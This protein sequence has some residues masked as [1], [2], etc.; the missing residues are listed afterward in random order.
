MLVLALDTCDSRGSLALLRDGVVLCHAAHDVEED[1]SRWLLPAIQGLLKTAETKLA[2]IDVYAVA[3]GPGL[4]TGVRLSLAT[5][6]AW[7]EVF[8]RPIV[9]VSRL[10]ALATCGDGDAPFVGAFVDANRGQVFASLY[11][12][13]GQPGNALQPAGLQPIGEEMVIA[14]E[15]FANWATER[16]AGLRMDWVS[17]DPEC[18]SRTSAWKARSARGE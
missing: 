17:L 15:D 4:F 8:G 1:Y 14:P 5:V 11:Q 18:L 6:K 13:Q 2:D 10:M 9:A 16:A 3:C 7:S 12:R